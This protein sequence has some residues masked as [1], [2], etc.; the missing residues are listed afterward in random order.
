MHL[1]CK[2]VIKGY[3]SPKAKDSKAK[4]GNNHV[5]VKKSK[6]GANKRIKALPKAKGTPV[7]VKKIIKRIQG[8]LSC[9]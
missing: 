9:C 1:R 2:G 7:E 4:A 6:N 8:K 3:A 5:R